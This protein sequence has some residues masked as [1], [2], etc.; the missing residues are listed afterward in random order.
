MDSCTITSNRSPKKNFLLKYYFF[1]TPLAPLRLLHLKK[2]QPLLILFFEGNGVNLTFFKN[3][4][5]WKVFRLNK[6]FTDYF[7]ALWIHSDFSLKR[8]YANIKGNFI[9]YA[10]HHN[11]N[12]K[13]L[14]PLI[15]SKSL[16][17]FLWQHSSS[18]FLGLILRQ[19]F[20]FISQK[21]SA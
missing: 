17:V 10:Y 7:R 2:F 6:F 13:L 1:K 4:F 20:H 21:E 5:S 9:Y 15:F 19:F 16:M 8:L 18:P 14:H 12:I 11:T 3:N